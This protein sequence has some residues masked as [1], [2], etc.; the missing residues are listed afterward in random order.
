MCLDLHCRVKLMFAQIWPQGAEKQLSLAKLGWVVMVGGGCRE[1]RPHQLLLL[2]SRAEQNCKNRAWVILLNWTSRSVR[3]LFPCYSFLFILI[4][5]IK[6]VVE[7]PSYD[8]KE[9]NNIISIFLNNWIQWPSWLALVFV[10]TT[11]VVFISF[12]HKSWR[13]KNT[14]C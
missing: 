9:R 10:S 3:V 4:E 1:Q 11:S 5:A 8:R 14:I 2:L 13:E 6:T 7:D 12:S